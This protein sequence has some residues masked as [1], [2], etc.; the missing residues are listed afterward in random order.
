MVH[1]YIC[2]REINYLG[3]AKH[4]AKEKRIHG[5]DVYKEYR[6]LRNEA[7]GT[8]TAGAAADPLPPS[9]QI[10]SAQKTLLQFGFSWPSRILRKDQYLDKYIEV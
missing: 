1:C 5:P 8:A 7:N 6:F 3:W 2:G 4:V 10:T 9:R